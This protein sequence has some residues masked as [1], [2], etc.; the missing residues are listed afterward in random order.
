[1]DGKH[2]E[3]QSRDLGGSNGFLNTAGATTSHVGKETS[4]KEDG[5]VVGNTQLSYVE[6]EKLQIREELQ[7]DVQPSKVED[8][9]LPKNSSDIR[10]SAA[11]RE[12]LLIE[13]PSS[14]YERQPRKINEVPDDVRPPVPT[15]DTEKQPRKINEVP[16]DGRPPVFTQDTEKQPRKINE[17]P[18]DV[19]FPV[20][21]QD[22]E[23]QPRKINDVPD[24][25]RPPVLT[26]DTEKQP[27]KKD[28]VHP[29]D[30]NQQRP[31][32]MEA[33]YG[34]QISRF[35]CRD[36]KVDVPILTVSP[37]Q[38][39]LRSSVH[40]EHPHSQTMPREE[41]DTPTTVLF[42]AEGNQRKSADAKDAQQAA[43]EIEKLRRDLS[44]SHSQIAELQKRCE[45]QSRD[46]EGS[47]SFLNTA[48]KSSDS[49]V[50]RALQRLNAEVQQTTLYMADCLAEDFEFKKMTTNPT[51]EQ[52]S[53]VQ[54]ASNHIGHILGKS[55]GTNKP[56]DLP[57]LLQIALQAYLASA[58]CQAASSWAFEPGYNTFIHGIYQRLRRAGEKLIV[59]IRPLF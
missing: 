36:S 11:D 48:D 37:I 57:M 49:D 25:V 27:R 47:N 22:T 5:V 7:K 8:E 34:V 12:G 24:D 1:V 33:Q 52:I 28:G 59:R 14:M 44:Q 50:I 51:Q 46:L 6:Q 13:E 41:K 19:R 29:L 55:L 43:R 18:D 45:A 9:I 31:P 10:P 17:I 2:C 32:P 56:E 30:V 53:A 16:D 40:D 21:A 26:Q 58:L 3:A 20:L 4:G 42:Y 35:K 15:Q 54:R 38:L 23:R 39:A